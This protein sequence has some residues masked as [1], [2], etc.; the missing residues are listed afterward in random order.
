MRRWIMKDAAAKGRREAL[1]ASLSAAF[2]LGFA[3]IVTALFLVFMTSAS[4]CTLGVPQLPTIRSGALFHPRHDD[5][6]VH[7]GR[8]GYAWIGESFATV[9]LRPAIEAQL[10]TGRYARIVVEA[11]RKV[12]LATL[13]PLFGAAQKYRVPVVL[14][15]QTVSVLEQTR[16][17]SSPRF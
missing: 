6:T 12:T 11:D 7:I 3:G 10:A 16:L 5:L 13:H 15:S 14:A 2:L 4:L 1:Q 8:N 17:E 9:D